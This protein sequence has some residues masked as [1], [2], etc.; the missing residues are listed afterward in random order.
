MGST[1]SP[2]RKLAANT[3]GLG[4]RV[5]GLFTRSYITY[6]SDQLPW[7]QG[8]LG[9]VTTLA[10]AAWRVDDPDMELALLRLSGPRLQASM[11]G[12]ILLAAWLDFLNLA[13]AVLRQCPFYGVE[14]LYMD[15]D[16]V[17]HLIEPSMKALASLEP[18]QVEAAATAMPELMGQLTREFHAIREAARVATERGGQM[19]AAAQFIEMITMVSMLRM[20]LPRPENGTR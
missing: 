11:S 8:A 4:S 14:R 5:N 2:L 12:A 10:D 20:S 18:G 17:R 19:M 13:D 6:G 9:G 16:R 3:H 7:I 15:M 1:A